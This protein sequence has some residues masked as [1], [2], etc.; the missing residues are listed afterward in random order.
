[1]MNVMSERT[2]KKEEAEKVG[3]GGG[4][5][6]TLSISKKGDW[7]RRGRGGEGDKFRDTKFR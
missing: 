5:K 1:M 2:L 4:D 7:R 6:A 3:E